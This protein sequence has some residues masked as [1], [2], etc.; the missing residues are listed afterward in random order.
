MIPTMNALS[1]LLNEVAT[2]RTR[3]CS[4]VGTLTEEQ[5]HWKPAPD[6]W[7]AVENTEHLYWAEHG[8]IWGMWRAFH[9]KQVGHAHLGR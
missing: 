3:F 4:E 1:Q 5:A 2:A 8:G 7:N 9:A 6:V